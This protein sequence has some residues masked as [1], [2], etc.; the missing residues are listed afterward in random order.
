MQIQQ[1]KNLNLKRQL[2]ISVQVI[3]L[4]F[5]QVLVELSKIKKLL[6]SSM[7]TVLS[8]LEVLKEMEKI[9]QLIQNLLHRLMKNLKPLLVNSV[10]VL[11]L[12]F[13][14]VLQLQCPPLKNQLT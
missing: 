1:R 9:F 13:N 12:I 8:G 14:L 2:P 5:V 3:E 4:F 11:V 7:K 6:T 10:I